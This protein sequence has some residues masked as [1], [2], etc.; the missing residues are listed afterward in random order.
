MG[1]APALVRILSYSSGLKGTH[2]LRDL[3]R[4]R[5]SRVDSSLPFTLPPKASIVQKRALLGTRKG[6]WRVTGVLTPRAFGTSGA[7]PRRGSGSRRNPVRG[8][9]DGGPLV[10]APALAVA[11]DRRRGRPAF[12]REAAAARS[13]PAGY[14]S[15]R[16]RATAAFPRPGQR[17]LRLRATSRQAAKGDRPSSRLQP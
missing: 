7:S 10:E 5:R 9:R 16:R 6:I 17:Q 11:A 15:V 8:S 1:S 13:N 4:Q 3:A 12:G 2:Q 14:A